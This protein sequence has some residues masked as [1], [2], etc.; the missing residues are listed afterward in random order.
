M[1]KIT[2]ADLA[3]VT[4]SSLRDRY[5]RVVQEEA[6]KVVYLWMYH[7][8]V[9]TYCGYFSIYDTPLVNKLGKSNCCSFI[10]DLEEHLKVGTNFNSLLP[11]NAT[12][13]VFE[14]T[15]LEYNKYIMAMEMLR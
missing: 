5:F 10:K 7:D 9:V 12:R 2:L 1:K 4:E 8:N 14:L 11:Q 3:G 6:G 13:E 15:E